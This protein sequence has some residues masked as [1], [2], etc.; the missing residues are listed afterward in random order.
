LSS[1]LLGDEENVSRMILDTWVIEDEITQNITILL[2]V[3][4]FK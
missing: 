3:L 4:A 2:A 1:L